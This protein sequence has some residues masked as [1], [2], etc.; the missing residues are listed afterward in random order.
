[1]DGERQPRCGRGR[2]PGT[3]DVS[4]GRSVRSNRRTFGRS[5]SGYSWST[6][7]ATSLFSILRMPLPQLD[8]VYD[9]ER[10]CASQAFYDAT[11]FW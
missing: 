5:G 2:C 3:R 1:M 10:R 7:R 4:P 8:A 9:H 6:E 11:L